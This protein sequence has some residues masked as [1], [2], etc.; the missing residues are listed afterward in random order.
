MYAKMWD[1][2]VPIYYIIQVMHYLIVYGLEY[3][4]I[5]SF[6]DGRKASLYSV[7]MDTELAEKIV[8]ASSAVLERE[9]C[10]R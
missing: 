3:G 4:E 5:V 7:S 1:S 10:S 6:I 2:G 9:S 8:S